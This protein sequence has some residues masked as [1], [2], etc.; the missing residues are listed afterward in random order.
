MLKTRWFLRYGPTVFRSLNLWP[1][2]VYFNTEVSTFV[3]DLLHPS[4]T[5]KSQAKLGTKI[6][7]T[8]DYFV[9]GKE[10]IKNRKEEENEEEQPEDI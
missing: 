6:G 3:R 5:Y 4:S 1:S 10:T 7:P 8:S 2:E 9:N